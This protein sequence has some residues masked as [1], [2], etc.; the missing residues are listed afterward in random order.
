MHIQ[1]LSTQPQCYLVRVQ[2]YS[3]S[4][5]VSARLEYRSAYSPGWEEKEVATVGVGSHVWEGEERLCDLTHNTL[6]IVRMDTYSTQYNFTTSTATHSIATIC[7]II[8]AL[9]L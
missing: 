2:L 8:T 5:L 7:V 9:Y 3:E 1:P 4:A 6:Y